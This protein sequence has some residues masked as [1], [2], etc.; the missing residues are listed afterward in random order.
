MKID[1]ESITQ[2]VLACIVCVEF[3]AVKL[4]KCQ[5]IDILLWT[6]LSIHIEQG[7]TALSTEKWFCKTFPPQELESK[8]ALLRERRARRGKNERL[9]SGRYEGSTKDWVLKTWCSCRLRS[10]WSS[11]RFN[12]VQESESAA[13]D[14]NPLAEQ[15][16]PLEI[17][18][19]STWHLLAG[20]TNPPRHQRC[21]CFDQAAHSPEESL[22]KHGRRHS[23]SQNRY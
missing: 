3:E 4:L 19:K 12:M 6:F 22:S 16:N 13:V 23:E 17:Y 7:W 9:L 1:I 5:N 15:I 11:K 2:N 20:H 8:W 14:W 21:W 18:L 10:S